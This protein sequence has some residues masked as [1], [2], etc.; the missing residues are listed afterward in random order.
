MPVLL[1]VFRRYIVG[2]LKMLT[3]NI[4]PQSKESAY[5]ESICRPV[6]WHH[7]N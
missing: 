5:E 3:L 1:N 2:L 4:H 7:Y 6:L